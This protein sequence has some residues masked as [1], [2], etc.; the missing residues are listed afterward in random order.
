[1]RVCQSCTSGDLLNDR[2]AWLAREARNGEAAEC[3]RRADDLHAE[4]RG[5][6]TCLHVLGYNMNADYMVDVEG[7][8]L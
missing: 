3:F 7:R 4:C 2:G 1:M 6:C 8:P 5:K